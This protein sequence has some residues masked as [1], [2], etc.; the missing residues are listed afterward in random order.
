MRAMRPSPKLGAR[1]L[2]EV[3]RKLFHTAGARTRTHINTCGP[4]P[5]LLG[6]RDKPTDEA[7]SADPQ[8]QV[9]DGFRR[10]FSVLVKHLRSIMRIDDENAIAFSEKRTQARLSIWMHDQECRSMR[11]HGRSRSSHHVCSNR[12][13]K[14]MKI[15]AE[16][17]RL[18]LISIKN[19]P[20]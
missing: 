13:D 7:V 8:D 15:S 20:V 14:F 2:L 9:T 16:R 5:S 3:G 6:L 4:Q 11:R 1:K 12:H 10:P 17:A 18:N 19:E